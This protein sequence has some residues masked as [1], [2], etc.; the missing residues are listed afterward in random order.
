[1]RGTRTSPDGGEILLAASDFEGKKIIDVANATISVVDDRGARS[2]CATTNSIWYARRARREWRVSRI[3]DRSALIIQR[4]WRKRIRRRRAANQI[5]RAWRQRAQTLSR[6]LHEALITAAGEGDLRR[7]AVLLGKMTFDARAR[8][9]T[10]V[11]ETER[12]MQNSV[13]TRRKLAM[14]AEDKERSTPRMTATLNEGG[15]GVAALAAARVGV[16]T[17]GPKGRMTTPLLVH[18]PTEVSSPACI[19]P[20]YILGGCVVQYRQQYHWRCCTIRVLG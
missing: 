8:T 15:Q 10:N 2:T 18:S 3:V 19:T 9:R 13:L 7:A 14:G 16:S 12:M 11:S 20:I 5:I 4:S 6:V 17:A 1:M